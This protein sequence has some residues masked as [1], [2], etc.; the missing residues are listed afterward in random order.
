MAMHAEKYNKFSVYHSIR[1][2]FCDFCDFC[3]T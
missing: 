3:V 2:A 1:K